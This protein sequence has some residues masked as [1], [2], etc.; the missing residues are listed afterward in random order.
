[1]GS[2]P[3]VSSEVQVQSSSRCIRFWESLRALL[4]LLAALRAPPRLRKGAVPGPPGS[5]PDPPLAA[6]PCAQVSA[7]CLPGAG[8]AS[9]PFPSSVALGC[10]WKPGG[11]AGG[12]F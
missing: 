12:L 4:W 9:Q 2:G 7:R 8:G 10:D 5:P 6:A 11:E 3:V 1:M